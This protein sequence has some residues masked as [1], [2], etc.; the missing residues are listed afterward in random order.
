MGPP[1]GEEGTHLKEVSLALGAP[2]S[3]KPGSGRVG[4]GTLPPLP[5]PPTH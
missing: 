2:P 5:P 4:P 3:G 1:P